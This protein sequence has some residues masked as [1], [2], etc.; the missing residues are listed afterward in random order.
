VAA[1]YQTPAQQ[2]QVKALDDGYELSAAPSCFFPCLE[3]RRACAAGQRLTT[4]LGQA[5]LQCPAQNFC[6]MGCAIN[7]LERPLQ[8]QP[9]GQV[10][11]CV[12]LADSGPLLPDGWIAT[13]T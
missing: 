11:P 9:G 3:S 8:R 4:P 1:G 10:P 6:G 5:H 7:R 12:A 13:L 2:S